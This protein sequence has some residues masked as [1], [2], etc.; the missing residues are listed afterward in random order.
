MQKDRE[1]LFTRWALVGSLG[2]TAIFSAIWIIRSLP[3]G[4]LLE[5]PMFTLGLVGAPLFVL[6]VFLA[7]WLPGLLRGNGRSTGWLL[8]IAA[9][10]LVIVAPEMALRAVGFTYESGV[11]YGKPRDKAWVR[12]VP[13]KD[14]MWTFPPSAPGV[15]SLGFHDKEIQKPKPDGVY[16][17]LF[18]GDSCT[19]QGFPDLVE[20]FLN[21]GNTNPKRQ[22]ESITM[23]V[24]G[25]TSHQGKVM[26]EKH[27][28]MAEPD[29][30][31]VYFGWNDHWQATGAPDADHKGLPPRSWWEQSRLNHLRVFQAIRK[32]S[33]AIS[34]HPAD[35]PVGEL[36][37]SPDQ[38]RKNLLRIGELFSA[39]NVPVIYITAPTSQYRL[40]VPDVL[41]ERGFVPDK[42]TGVRLHKSYNEIAREAAKRPM[43]HLLDLETEFERLPHPEELFMKDGIHFT[44]AGLA[45]VAKRVSEM[46][47]QI[48]T[49]LA[50]VPSNRR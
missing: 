35:L 16:R 17:I 46:A 34:P 47:H 44:S 26:A 5:H 49:P 42:A 10:N 3:F 48:A 40:G 41:I 24:T 13:D 31:V 11:Q 23:A 8:T 39:R 33:A 20:L 12:L 2:C 1:L 25:Y 29:L 21:A 4:R 6:L 9:F 7:W 32:M 28:A 50:S 36:R 37:V 30:V 43:S 22:F 15:N 18:L 38:Y 27:G 19:E 14:L 45:L